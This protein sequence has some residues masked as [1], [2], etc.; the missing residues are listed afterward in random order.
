[1]MVSAVTPMTAI[2]SM[3]AI[4]SVT[5]VVVGIAIIHII[6]DCPA[7]QAARNRADEHARKLVILALA[8]TLDV[9]DRGRP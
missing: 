3:A 7:D 9:L 8:L 4:P 5:P 1:M 2:T 6:A